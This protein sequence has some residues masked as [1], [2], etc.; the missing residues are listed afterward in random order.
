MAPTCHADGT[1]RGTVLSLKSRMSS[2]AMCLNQVG[3]RIYWPLIVP[4]PVAADT[5]VICLSCGTPYTFAPGAVSP[6]SPP[7]RSSAEKTY[8]IPYVYRFRSSS[9]LLRCRPDQRI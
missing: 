3:N 2:W 5:L 6:C 9:P 7:I 8:E 1:L 4:S